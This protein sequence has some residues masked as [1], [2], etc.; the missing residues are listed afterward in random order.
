LHLA[1]RVSGDGNLSSG[2]AGSIGRAG[3]GGWHDAE[4][5]C[6]TLEIRTGAAADQLF[7]LLCVERNLDD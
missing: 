4:N 1:D 2:F 6:V 7:A 5:D 3:C